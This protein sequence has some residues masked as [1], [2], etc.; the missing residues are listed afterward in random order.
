MVTLRNFIICTL[1]TVL[2]LLVILT[3]IKGVLLVLK[4]IKCVL[5]KLTDSK[6]ILSHVFKSVKISLTLIWKILWFKF[7]TKTLVSSAKRIGDEFLFRIMG[8]SLRYTKKRNGPGMDPCGTPLD[9]LP[10]LNKYFYHYWSVL[11]LADIY[12]VSKILLH[13]ALTCN[14]IKL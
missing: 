4:W 7:V 10:S 14:S 12:P 3:F 1:L 5:S 9:T 13:H 11:L 2:W 6:L 8:R